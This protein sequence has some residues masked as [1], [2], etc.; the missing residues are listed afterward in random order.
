[1]NKNITRISV[2]VG[3]SFLMQSCLVAKKYERPNLKAEENFRTEVVEKD[4]TSIAKIEWNKVFTD[5]YLQNYIQQ[6][7]ENNYDIQIAAQNIAAAEA[8]MKRGK[9][10]YFPTINASATWTHQEISKNSQFGGLFSQL[11]QYQLSPSLSWEAD[12]WGKIRSNKRATAATY[13]QSVA[14]NKALQ[15]QIIGSIASVYYQLLSFDAQLKVAEAALKNREKSVEVIKSLKEGGTVNEVGVKQTE[16][17]MLATK[18]TIEDIKYNIG[19]LENSLSILIGNAPKSIERASLADQKID[20]DIST[21]VPSTLLAN[22]ADLIAAEYNLMSTFEQTNVARANFYPSFTINATS[23]FQALE[24]KDLFNANSLF[25]NIVTG[26]TA[27]ILNGRAI[28]TNFEVAKANQQKAFLQ[29][30]KQ[31]LVAI[32]E[33]SNAFANY[34]NETKKIKIREQQVDLLQKAVEYSDELLV[35]GMVNYLDVITASDSAL[36][37]E[38]SLIDNKYKQLNAIITLYRSLGGGWQ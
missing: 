13:L 37:A 19:V 1:M 9:A 31:Y 10:G 14:T 12:I 11:D 36:N 30:E 34:E 32:Q 38:L 6:G 3:A 17:Q 21:G 4:T 15:A 29:Y 2:V 26:L 28:K 5:Q 22:R 18:V 20:I 7:L 33:V 23:G 8:S 35:Y 24:T 25:A 16:S 27:P